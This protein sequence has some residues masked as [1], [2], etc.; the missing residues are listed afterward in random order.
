M[1]G[2]EFTLRGMGY[3][4]TIVDT[5]DLW[6]LERS[7]CNDG[8][9]VLALVGNSQLMWSLSPAIMMDNDPGL[10]VKMLAVE[11]SSPVPVLEDLASDSSFIGKVICAI[12][13]ADILPLQHDE[14]AYLVNHYRENFG[15]NDAINR[16]I[17]TWLQWRLVFMDPYVNPRRLAQEWVADGVLPGQR[18]VLTYPDRSRRFDYSL[19]NVKNRQDSQFAG[20]DELF[21]NAKEIGF[22]AWHE[23]ASR[24]AL[25]EKAIERRGGHVLFVRLPVDI[26][27]WEMEEK[28]F[29]KSHYWDAWVRDT[30]VQA[31]HFDDYPV[32]DS[33]VYP[34]HYHIDASDVSRFTKTLTTIIQQQ[35]LL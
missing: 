24:L 16:Q 27:A 35:R 10:R 2:A 25:Y 11:G 4:S 30:G 34:D 13:P 12:N 14:Q 8:T 20:T 18:P 3:T 29:P 19:V 17:S 32:F 28:Y 7:R 1:L 6:A 33:F 21:R 15:L 26:K 9:N 5:P 22:E 23:H 31:L